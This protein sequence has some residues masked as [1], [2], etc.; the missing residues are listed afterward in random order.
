MYVGIL[1]AASH[2]PKWDFSHAIVGN[3]TSLVW[4]TARS[5]R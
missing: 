4:A 5:F 1:E 3:S 2:P